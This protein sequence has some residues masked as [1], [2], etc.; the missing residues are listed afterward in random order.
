MRKSILNKF[1]DNL[2]GYVFI[3]PWL[4]GFIAFLLVPLVVSFN[5]PQFLSFA[6]FYISMCTIYSGSTGRT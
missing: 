2:T 1:Y 5:S 4:I 6:I 3:L